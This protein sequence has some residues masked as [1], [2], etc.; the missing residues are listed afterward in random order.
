MAIRSELAERVSH[1]VNKR[2]KYLA[3]AR[4]PALAKPGD[5]YVTATGQQIKSEK[6]KNSKKKDEPEITAKTFKSSKQRTLAD[7]PATPPIIN[8]CAVVIIY[9]IMGLGDREIAIAAK[10]KHEDVLAVK[11]HPA[12]EECFEI[13]AKEFL[14]ANSELLS[15]RVASYA[16][17]AVS[18][19]A[20][21]SQ[22]GKQESN[23]L[24][25]SMHL[26]DAAVGGKNGP[27]GGAN[28]HVNELRIVIVE[29]DRNPVE[30]ELNG[31]SF[32]SEKYGEEREET[33]AE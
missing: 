3:D 26:H 32:R 17:D 28:G 5:P 18:K 21:I 31:Q 11:S 19:I 25:A 33:A 9:T 4:R 20:E 6:P 15:A 14:T 7:L 22:N 27:Q 23:Q 24:R 10:I 2:Q 13:I 16:H 1:T 8:G 29:G 12:Y 30:L